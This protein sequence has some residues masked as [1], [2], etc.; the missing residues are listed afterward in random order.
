MNRSP[1]VE[2]AYLY[3]DGSNYKAWGSI[4]FRH[5]RRYSI[6]DLRNR[7]VA[8]IHSEG[9]FTAHQV[10]IPEL[11]L[12]LDGD[13]TPDDHCFHEFHD[14][15]E[16]D[17]EPSDGLARTIEEFVHEME[18]QGSRGWEAF[19]PAMRALRNVR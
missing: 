19:E 5:D 7:I 10:R 9:T 8:A 3:R 12:Y 6:D 13:V 15:A 17:A 16:T 2:F 14:L 11:F 18:L 4:V 1:N